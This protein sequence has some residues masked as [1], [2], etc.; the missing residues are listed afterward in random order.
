M[1]ADEQKG[2][3]DL[4]A[5]V[6]KDAVPTYDIKPRTKVVQKWKMSDLEPRLTEVQKGRN[7]DKG[8]EA[9]M[10]G[11]C[12]KCHRVGT[13]GGAVGPDLTAIASRFS[14]R[15]ML[16]SVLEPSKVISDQYQNERVVTKKGISHVGRIV[17]ESADRI[18][19]QPDPLSPTR[20][21]VRKSAIETREPSKL[22][23]MPAGLADVLTAE[24]VLD[25][26]A[27]M[28]A[29]GNRGHRAFQK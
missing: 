24:E 10:A 26:V 20:V 13:E 5:K 3:A 28:E 21:E 9:Y 7:F 25:L 18:V 16:E 11:Q 2:L 19:I 29:G 4:I 8:R 17:D 1:S 6:D 22:S 12:I 15:D 14:R 27:F 23:P